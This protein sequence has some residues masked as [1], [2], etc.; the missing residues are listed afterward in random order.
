MELAEVVGHLAV[1]RRFPV[2]PLGGEE[3]DEARLAGE[4]LLGD[5]EYVLLEEPTGSPLD[6]ESNPFLLGCRARVVGQ[7]AAGEPEGRVLVRV[8]EGA[9]FRL[10]DSAWLAEVSRRFGQPVRMA[11]RRDLPGGAPGLHLV[12]TPT[13]GFLERAYGA[14][15]E[16]ARLRAN[17]VVDLHEGAAFE[18]DHWVGQRIRIG[19]AQFDVVSPSL[20]CVLTRLEPESAAGD[21]SMLKGVLHVRGGSLGVQVRPVSGHRVRVADPMSLVS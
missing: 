16:P 12:S 17:F 5:R 15:L 2:E 11:A 20:G 10:T 9:E 6:P 1:L 8:S 19:D 4:D 18:E 13:L 3:P 14:P 21:V 7:L